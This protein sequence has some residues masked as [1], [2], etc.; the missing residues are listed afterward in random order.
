MK[1]LRFAAIGIALL[2]GSIHASAQSVADFYRG[3]QIRMMI[4]APAG[5]GYDAVGRMI[6]AV[7]GKHVP[8]NPTFV[9]EN[10]G[11]AAGLVMANTLYNTAPKD[12]TAIGLPTSAIPLEPRLK[13]L[14]RNGGTASFDIGKLGWIGSA[15]QQP[16]V[17]FVW[18]E[19]PAKTA[20]D[21]KT[22]KI[23]MGTLAVG[24]DSYI[25]PLMMNEV[26]GAKMELVP[27]YEGFADTLVA[28]ERG[29]IQG[30]SAGLANLMSARPDWLADGKVR[31]LIQFGRE[32]L[33]ELPD[34]PTAAELA[35]TDL[36]R[37]MLQF[38]SL[39]YN[40]AY[41]LI[42]P[43]GVPP[44]RLAALRAAF[45]ATMKDPEYIAAA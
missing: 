45:D 23:L 18:H 5:G 11:T 28:I 2:A 36:D 7:M 1:A 33:P 30:H 44:D 35:S 4:G 38:Y 6:A 42:A 20:A 40:M 34:V 27:G 43:P 25:L 31:M 29:E 26:M 17:L 22:T 16:Q 9:V 37:Q 21:L 12:G 24:S 32:R 14:T 39:K 10:I 41:T 3:K 8:G 15:A 19:A 13:L